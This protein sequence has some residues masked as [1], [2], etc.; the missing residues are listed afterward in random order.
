MVEWVLQII[1]EAEP[2]LARA[3]LDAINAFSDLERPC[4][5]T[6]LLANV[7]LHPLIHVYDVLYIRGSG[8]LWYYDEVGN[9]VL[10]IL[11]KRGV[12]Q[13][14]VL[15]TTILCITARPVCNTLR[16]L[17]GVEVF[18]SSYANDVYMRGKTVN[19]AGTHTHTTSPDIYI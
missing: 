16:N 6:T 3:T 14:C 4:I 5:Q 10:A 9:F 8:E 12:R 2:D 18:M 7:I 13:G 1:M 15:G 11:C 19:V 17:L